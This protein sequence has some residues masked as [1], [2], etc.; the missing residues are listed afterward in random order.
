ML[1]GIFRSNKP[2][3]LFSLPNVITVIWVFAFLNPGEPN[4]D[5]TMPFYVLF[6]SVIAKFPLIANCLAILLLVVQAVVLNNIIIRHQL[7]YRSNYLPSVM[8]VVIMSSCPSLLSLHPVL[9]ANLF[10]IIA[11]SRVLNIYRQENIFSQVFDAGFFIGIASLF[12][13]PAIVF[14][15]FVFVSL[16]VL[17]PFTWREWVI[18]GLGLLSPYFFVFVYYYWFDKLDLFWDES[19]IAPIV[20]KSF[21]VTLDSSFYL[22]IIISFGIMLLA[23][24]RLFEGLRINTVRAKKLL[25]ILVWF[26]VFSVISVLLAPSLSVKYFSILAIPLSIYSG[27]Y[28]LTARNKWLREGIFL[29]LLISIVYVQVINLYF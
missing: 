22:L 8:Y 24:I 3:V 11:L 18:P 20:N 19:I 23:L 12:Y 28:F 15:P 2:A 17:R 25:F 29:L 13:F 5:Q 14:F 27:S 9:F 21:S 16:I 10:L 26:T 4:V 1:V 7:F 6:V